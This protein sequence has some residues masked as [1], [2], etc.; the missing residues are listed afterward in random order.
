MKAHAQIIFVIFIVLLGFS[1][2]FSHWWFH[3]AG[4]TGVEVPLLKWQAPA[5]AIDQYISGTRAGKALEY[6]YGLQVI[7]QNKGE[8]P[9]AQVNYLEYDEG[10]YWMLADVYQHSPEICLPAAGAQLVREYPSRDFEI[11]DEPL[12]VRHWL[13]K[14]PISE[15]P[16]HAFKAIWSTNE[17]LITKFSDHDVQ[18]RVRLKAAAA[19]QVLPPA[20]MILVIVSGAPN[21]KEAW[22]YLER[23]VFS[24]FSRPGN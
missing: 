22:N 11:E 16:L 4:D 14:H 19:G 2:G 23:E 6:D 5:D 21:E 18:R 8:G 1:E 7:L 24:Q 10:N 9:E 20:R 12:T 3:K 13:F 15:A 17:D